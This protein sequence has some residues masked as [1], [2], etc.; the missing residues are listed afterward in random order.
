[1][2]KKF[3]KVKE[4]RFPTTGVYE[5]IDFFPEENRSILW[6]YFDD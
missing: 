2:K 3:N 4:I 6:S 5:I 1:M